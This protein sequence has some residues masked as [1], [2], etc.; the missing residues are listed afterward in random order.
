MP[1]KTSLKQRMYACIASTHKALG[2]KLLSEKGQFNI[3][4]YVSMNKQASGF[5]FLSAG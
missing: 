1:L 4:F 5:M 3:I 2:I